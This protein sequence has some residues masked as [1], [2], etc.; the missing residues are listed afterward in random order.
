MKHIPAQSVGCK[1]GGGGRCSFPAW[2]HTVP[3][4][5]LPSLA[6][7]YHLFQE[8]IWSWFQACRRPSHYCPS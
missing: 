7:W 4:P 6:R 2:P 3:A 8:N 5:S 1:A